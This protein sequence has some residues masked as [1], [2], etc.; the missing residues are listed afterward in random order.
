MLFTQEH[1]WLDL[2]DQSVVVGITAYAA[3]H[4]GDVVFVELPQ[5]GKVV[6]AGDSLAVVESVKAASDVYAPVD[7]EVVEVND[8]LPASP[9]QVNLDPEGSAWLV[10]IKLAEPGQIDGLM[11]RAAYEAFLG[12]L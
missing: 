5:V 10:R 8:A 3:E 1:E 6:K 9:E 11:D 12:A 4:L 7:G 2:Q